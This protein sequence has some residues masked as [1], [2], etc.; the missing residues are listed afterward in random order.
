M[1]AYKNL[2]DLP[3]TVLATTQK[4]NDE[5]EVICSM[6]RRVDLSFALTLCII[7]FYG[8]FYSR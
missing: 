4:N 6:T 8:H 3:A 1:Q 2:I 7:P 5:F